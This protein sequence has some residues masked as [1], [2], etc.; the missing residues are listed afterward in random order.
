MGTGLPVPQ[1]VSRV[2][3]SYEPVCQRPPPPVFHALVLSFQVS[4]PGSPGLGTTYQRHSSLPDRASS[5]ASQ[6][7]VLASPAPLAMIT[8]PSAVIGPALNRS[9]L[10]NSLVTATILSQTIS[11]VLVF[12]AMTRPSGRLAITRSSHNAMPRV[13]GLLPWCLTPGSVT[14]TN[15]PRFGFLPSILYR[16]PQP[17]LVYRKPLS[18]SGLISLS[19]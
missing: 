19:G 3:G 18:T 15:S 10:P 1:I 2:V 8:L 13:C 4:L 17:S 12:A 11:P 5:A 7:R 16:L 6:P 14:Q 9:R